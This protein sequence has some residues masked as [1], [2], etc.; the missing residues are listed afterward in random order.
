[1]FTIMI[2]ILGGRSDMKIKYIPFVLIGLF[3]IYMSVYMYPLVFDD[4]TAFLLMLALVCGLV[5]LG[6]GIR[7][8]WMR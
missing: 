3:I 8:V 1:M 6:S 7:L 2:L 4:L 5:T